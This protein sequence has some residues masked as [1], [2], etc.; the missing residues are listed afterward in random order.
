M[1]C[2]NKIKHCRSRYLFFKM[3]MKNKNILMRIFNYCY[4]SNP[5]VRKA[6]AFLG[7]LI[8]LAGTP[9]LTQAAMTGTDSVP[10]Q[11]ISINDDWRFH[12]YDSGVDVRL[13]NT[14]VYDFE[15]KPVEKYIFSK[16]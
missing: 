12:K 11:R 6:F 3:K 2:Q 4:L 5:T 14:F 10:R 15:T 7:C 9:A 8:L 13:K 16:L 1:Y